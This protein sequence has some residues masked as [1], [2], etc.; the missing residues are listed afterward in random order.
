[1][2]NRQARPTIRLL[3][4]DLPD[5]WTDPSILRHIS[6]GHFDELHPLPHLPHPIVQKAAETFGEI[7][8]EDNPVGVIRSYTRETLWE[9]KQAQW[10]GGVWI[11]ESTGVCW[12]VVAGLAKGDHLDFDDFYQV[13]ER[14]NSN[15]DSSRWLPTDQD[16][17]LLKQETAARL[18]REWELEI[19]RRVWKSLEELRDGG[20]T[21][22]TIGLPHSPQERMADVS[23]TVS[24]SDNSSVV[25]GDQAID[26]VFV[27][28]FPTNEHY[29]SN[30]FWR[31]VVRVLTSIEP[32]EIGWDSLGEH[33]YGNMVGRDTWNERLETLSGLVEQ[34]ILANS[35]PDDSS[36]YAHR[37]SLVDRLV[38]GKAVRTLCGVYFVQT[39]DPEKLEVCPPVPAD[40]RISAHRS[41]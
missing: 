17:S 37:K 30:L 35:V 38:E 11:D 13:V 19:Q 6:N 20:E 18:L 28:F 26:D 3:T 9:I 15:D 16:R 1:M 10:R 41:H 34:Q 5:G 39:Q 33:Y 14:E 24:S 7:A 4:E 21:R 31:L 2:H 25:S 36:H 27:E 29:T 22:I 8:E 32:P 23:I 12:L 40:F